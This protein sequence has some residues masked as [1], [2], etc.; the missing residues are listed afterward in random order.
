[1]LYFFADFL[2]V[3]INILVGGVEEV[4]QHGYGSSCFLI[5]ELWSFL[6]FLHFLEC[7]LPSLDEH[8]ELSIE[9]GYS[10][11]LSDGSYDD[12]AVLGLNAVDELFE[13]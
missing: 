8:L 10:F 9:L 2:V 7:V 6:G 11:A 4:T 1:M 13:S 3:D 12:A 5:D